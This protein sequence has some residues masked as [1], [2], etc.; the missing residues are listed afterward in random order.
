MKCAHCGAE[1][2]PGDAVCPGCGQAAPRPAYL[3]PPDP[4]ARYPLREFPMALGELIGWSERKVLAAL[5]Q[6]NTNEE[7]LYWRSADPGTPGALWRNQTG[8]LATIHVFGPVPSRIPV[9][10]PYRTWT[11]H[12]VR[13]MTWL[14]YLAR[15][16]VPD[17]GQAPAETPSPPGVWAR[18]ARLFGKGREKSR[19]RH[20]VVVEVDRY[21]TGAIF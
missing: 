18:L 14:L 9:G 6:P 1:L 3:Q 10:T 13:G 21:P 15:L 2:D 19:P 16:P 4:A 7:G 11:Y 12:N 20:R 5:G 8:E 17:A